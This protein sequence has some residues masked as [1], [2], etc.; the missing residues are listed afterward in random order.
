MDLLPHGKTVH[1]EI[2]E[3]IHLIRTVVGDEILA[4]FCVRTPFLQTSLHVIGMVVVAEGCVPCPPP[5][6][7]IESLDGMI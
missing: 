2:V 7:G 5:E 6:G 4:E 1:H 3:F